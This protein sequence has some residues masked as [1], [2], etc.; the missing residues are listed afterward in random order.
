M[1]RYGKE[2]RIGNEL[3]GTIASYMMDEIREDLHQEIAPCSNEEFINKY[4]E[5]DPEFSK[6]LESEFEIEV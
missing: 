1:K 4:L 3:M 2:I 5:R 6:I